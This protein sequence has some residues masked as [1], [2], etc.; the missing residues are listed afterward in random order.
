M[1]LI[2][3]ISSI[4]IIFFILINSPKA[5]NLNV[6]GNQSNILNSTRSTQKGLQA[7]TVINII[8][9]FVLIIFLVLYY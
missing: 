8:I 3:Y 9:F 5:A 4:L 7:L 6:F 1:K 2:W